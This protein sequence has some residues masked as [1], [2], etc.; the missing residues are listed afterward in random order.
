MLTF[1]VDYASE[2]SK[3]LE[4]DSFSPIAALLVLCFFV[5]QIVITFLE[6]K[7]T[8]EESFK[9][10]IAKK[11]LAKIFNKNRIINE[12]TV[13]I[14]NVQDLIT[15]LETNNL[16][17]Y[18]PELIDSAYR[19]KN[20]FQ[21]NDKN[22]KNKQYLVFKYNQVNDSLLKQ[23]GIKTYREI[24]SDTLV[25]IILIIMGLSLILAIVTPSPI[26]IIMFFISTLF[27]LIVMIVLIIFLVIEGKKWFLDFRRK[28]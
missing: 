22:K 1:V 8:K 25:N 21:D 10:D 17:G 6:Y 3:I 14:E 11:T 9:K 2:I 24:S 4:K 7:K 26:N 15:A 5:I 28:K 23:C 20:N 13:T 16:A 12:D 18:F 19:V 27:M